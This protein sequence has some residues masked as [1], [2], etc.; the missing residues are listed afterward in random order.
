MGWS[1]GWRVV[2]MC[3]DMLKILSFYA[4]KNSFS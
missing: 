2:G 1:K 3:D 4:V